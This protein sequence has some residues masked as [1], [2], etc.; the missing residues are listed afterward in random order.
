MLWSSVGA[1]QLSEWKKN[2]CHTLS[3]FDSNSAEEIAALPK[4][5]AD[6]EESEKKVK[7]IGEVCFG[8]IRHAV[9]HQWETLG[10]QTVRAGGESRLIP[11]QFNVPRSRGSDL[12][13]D[14]DF[15]K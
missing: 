2:S 7:V 13:G 12:S 4:T 11:L 15:T 8:Q 1:S 10:K 5:L 6:G 9:L 14:N 3:R